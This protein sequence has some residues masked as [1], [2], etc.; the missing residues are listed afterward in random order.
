MVAYEEYAANHL[1]LVVACDRPA[2]DLCT[3]QFVQGQNA[4]HLYLLGATDLRAEDL[5]NQKMMMT[6]ILDI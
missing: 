6:C 1:K 4:L 2:G 5:L 3:P